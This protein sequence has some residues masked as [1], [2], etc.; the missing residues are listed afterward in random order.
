MKHFIF[1]WV[2]QYDINIEGT[3]IISF[4]TKYQILWS[5]NRKFWCI[6][7]FNFQ[8]GI[9][10]FWVYYFWQ[11]IIQS[12]TCSHCN[13]SQ[14]FS[15]VRRTIRWENINI[16]YW[17]ELV[18]FIIWE[19]LVLFIICEELEPSCTE[20]ILICIICEELD[21]S[22]SVP[23]MMIDKLAGYKT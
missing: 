21:P 19:E 15:K 12:F 8:M 16:Y 18:L 22:W 6:S 23:V 2:N 11:Y 9:V 20:R 13:V 3:I 17:E 14:I 7:K 10:I 1:F 5:L 4:W